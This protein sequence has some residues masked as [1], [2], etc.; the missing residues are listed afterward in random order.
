M[1][2]IE[3]MEMQDQIFRVIVPTEEEIEIKTPAAHGS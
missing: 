1:H 3:T 2:R